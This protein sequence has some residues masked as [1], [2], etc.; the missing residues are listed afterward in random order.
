MVL[1][2]NGVYTVYTNSLWCLICAKNGGI[3]RGAYVVTFCI[4][5]SHFTPFDTHQHTT[6]NHLRLQYLQPAVTVGWRS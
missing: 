6:W 2:S 1:P 3:T 5:L 4:L